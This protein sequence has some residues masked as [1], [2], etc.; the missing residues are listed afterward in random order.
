MIAKNDRSDKCVRNEVHRG[1][2]GSKRFKGSR[3]FKTV[4]V[5]QRVRAGMSRPSASVSC[6]GLQRFPLIHEVTDFPHE[7]LM[8]AG[9]GVG[10]GAVV[11]ESWRGHLGFEFLDR[12]FAVGDARFEVGN[13]LVARV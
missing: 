6:L 5:V 11:E 2:R 12:A 9:G 1:S 8:A 13:A 10:G 4:Q 3:R 7:C